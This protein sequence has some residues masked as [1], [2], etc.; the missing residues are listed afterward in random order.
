ME[1]IEDSRVAAAY[2]NPD[3][4]FSVFQRVMIMDPLVAFRSNRQRDQNRSRTR[5]VRASDMER[6]KADVAALFK[7]VFIERLEAD[8]GFEVV[9]VLDY[10][11]LVLRPAIVDLDITSPDTMSGGRTRTMNASAGAATLY[12]ELFDGV[13]GQIIG[14]A[15]DRR[16]ARTAGGRISWSN[17]VTNSAEARR[18]FGRWADL[19]R[20]FLDQHY[21][22]STQ[23]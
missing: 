17:R 11:V 8:E 7:Q 3:A 23:D 18:M 5:N 22:P 14:R 10:D 19:L 20:D 4:D 6:I 9:D 15:A 2:I 12:I 13:S 21:V 16:T 1:R